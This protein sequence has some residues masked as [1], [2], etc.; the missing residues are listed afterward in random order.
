V[1]HPE[2]QQDVFFRFVLEIYFAF[3]PAVQNGGG[4]SNSRIRRANI[5]RFV[6]HIFHVFRSG[7]FPLSCITVIGLAEYWSRK[8]GD[9]HDFGG[10]IIFFTYRHNYGL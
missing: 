9:F 2:R 5:R 3:F 4:Q 8:S 1:Y 6:P 7:D 10:S